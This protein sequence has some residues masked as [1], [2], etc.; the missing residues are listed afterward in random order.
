MKNSEVHLKV[1]EQREG[2]K[3]I[4]Q[5]ITK[6]RA[7]TI[8]QKQTPKQNKTMKQ[9]VDSEK[10]INTFEKFFSKLTKG[11]KRLFKWTKL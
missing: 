6:P 2:I 9:R 3:S 4:E 8:Q 11:R 10:K 1:L 7:K 5:E